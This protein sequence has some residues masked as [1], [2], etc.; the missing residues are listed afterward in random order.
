MDRV[1]GLQNSKWRRPKVPHFSALGLAAF[2]VVVIFVFFFFI[3][4]LLGV[5]LRCC[6]VSSEYI[7]GVAV[8]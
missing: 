1:S 4:I 6:F 7:E 2:G 3:V 5:C 8:V